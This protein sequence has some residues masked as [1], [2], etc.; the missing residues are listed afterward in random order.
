MRARILQPS[1][2]V[3]GHRSLSAEVCIVG[4][5]AAGIYLAVRLSQW[6]IRVLLVEAGST[7][8]QDSQS[9]GFETDFSGEVYGGAVQGR[10]F[11]LGG[12]TV[13]W[14]GQ[15]FPYLRTHA[16]PFDTPWSTTWPTIETTVAQHQQSVLA[17]LGLPDKCFSADLP[18]A[19]LSGCEKALREEGL[20][21]ASSVWLPFR[22]RNFV[23]LLNEESRPS[24]TVL[25]NAVAAGWQVVDPGSG[26]ACV[27]SL[28]VHC[29]SRTLEITAKYFVITAGT[30]ESA[31]L[32]LELDATHDFRILPRSAAC[33]CYLSDHLSLA[34]GSVE[35]EASRRLVSFF[36]PRFFRYGMR[37]VRILGIG[38]EYEAW[39]R[40]FAH[41]TFD[42]KSPGFSVA[43]DF[44]RSFQ[45]GRLVTPPMGL[46]IKS[47]PSLARL[48]WARFARQRLAV[49]DKTYVHLQLDFEQ[50]PVQSNRITLGREKDR[51]GRPRATIHWQISGQ[52]RRGVS[53]VA[54]RILSALGRMSENR[55]VPRVLPCASFQ[56]AK[57]YDV[58]H[59]VGTTMLGD[60]PEAVVDTDCLVRGTSNLWTLS[61]GIF[62]SAGVANPT[63]SL[64]CF[65]D[66]LAQD[67]KGK[68]D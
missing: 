26:P 64:L 56:E 10:Y 19:G 49:P 37:S 11:G 2:L 34:I 51:H 39:P 7:R 3:E 59:P 28:V 33:G 55:T 1:D 36:A 48:G 52:D 5:G 57:L 27:R 25:T 43:R 18:W 4:A 38:P 14:G 32:L 22:S 20:S 50:Y 68:F 61:T 9:I 24:L 53:A 62:P 12:T 23:R 15:L 66:R 40:F 58:Y 16:R 65:A 54:E 41:W 17:L 46:L 13:Q 45:S 6:G 30:I 44:F 29:A 42:Q 63:F 31:R 8:A 21:I 67:L 35:P 60:H 47:L